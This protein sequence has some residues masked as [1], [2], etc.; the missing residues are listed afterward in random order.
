MPRFTPR[1]LHTCSVQLSARDF[2][3]FILCMCFTLSVLSTCQELP[4]NFQMISQIRTLRLIFQSVFTQGPL[5]F[6]IYL[7]TMFLIKI[8]MS[9]VWETNTSLRAMITLSSYND[10]LNIKSTAWNIGSRQKNL[11][12]NQ[13]TKHIKIVNFILDNCRY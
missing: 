5:M 1:S 2:W 3:Q 7:K 6:Y 9:T 13:D 8:A 11:H 10:I 12:V 4:V